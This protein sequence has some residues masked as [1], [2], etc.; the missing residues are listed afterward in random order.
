MF[1]RKSITL[2]R[3]Q[4][5]MNGRMPEKGK[6]KPPYVELVN[7]DVLPFP[8]V[9]WNE[10][11]IWIWPNEDAAAFPVPAE[12]VVSVWLRPEDSVE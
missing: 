10:K 8:S 6:R 7:R 1:R 9:K 11:G 12:R 2:K 4:I 3:F 5:Q